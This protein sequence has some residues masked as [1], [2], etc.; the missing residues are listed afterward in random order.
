MSVLE[1]LGVVV[2][3]AAGW[4]FFDSLQARD[5]AIAAARAACVSEGL[6]FLDDTVAIAGVRPRR[7][8]EG[9]LKLQRA[10]DFEYSDSGDNRI[11]GSIVM[12]GREVAMLN[13]GSR[14]GANVIPLY[15]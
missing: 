9:R 10:Y 11:R 15:R 1:I 5:A 7:D 12:L 2:L 3:A 6:M 13:V 4:Y 14:E 8:G